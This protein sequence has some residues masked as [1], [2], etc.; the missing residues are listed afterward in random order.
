[1]PEPSRAPDMT[2]IGDEDDLPAVRRPAGRQ[3]VIERTVVVAG[4]IALV[5]FGQTLR[6]SGRAGRVELDG[7]DVEA[8]LVDG[9]DEHQTP[10]IGREARLDVDR[11]VAGDRTR[12]S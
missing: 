4:Q 10:A 7:V 2:A 6:L 1:P 9:R 8:P 5:I 12:R 11:P 3:V